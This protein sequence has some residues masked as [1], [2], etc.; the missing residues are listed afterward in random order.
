M[1]D[2]KLYHLGNAVKFSKEGGTVEFHVKIC[3]TMLG[4]NA[5]EARFPDVEQACGGKLNTRTL[6]FIVKDYGCGIKRED[7]KVI[8]EPFSQ[9]GRDTAGTYGG[10]GLGLAITMRLV[11]ALGGHI[12]VHSEF[13]KWSGFT[14]DLPFREELADVVAEAQRLRNTKI[15]FVAHESKEVARVTQLFHKYGISVL[16]Y[17]HLRDI[18]IRADDAKASASQILY[19]IHESSYS[20]TEF[21]ELVDTSN[22]SLA[23]FGPSFSVSNSCAHFNSLTE[24]LPVVLLRRLRECVTNNTA[25][26]Y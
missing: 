11:D 15:V 9:A 4:T 13:G 5:E 8:F 3:D 23:T 26:G 19:L 25:Q 17:Q 2:F 6:R 10:T 14:V 7:L 16:R 24:I 1:T 22:T 18:K 20:K 21:D 12:S